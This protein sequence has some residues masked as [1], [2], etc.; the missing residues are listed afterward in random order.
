[1]SPPLSLVRPVIQPAP[2]ISP[3][4][5]GTAHPVRS[6][7]PQGAPALPAHLAAL[8]D[9]IRPPRFGVLAFGDPR[10]DAHLSGG[11][12]ALGQLHEIGGIGVGTETGAL[13][14]GFAASLAGRIGGRQ[15]VFWI[16]PRPDLYP[17]G[18]TDFGLDPARLVLVRPDD[19]DATLAAMETALREGGAGVVIGEVETLDRVASRRLALACARH[20]TTCLALRRWP[21]GRRGEDRDT[22]LAATRWRLGPVPSGSVPSD[23]DAKEPGPPR[24]LLALTQARGGRPGEWIVEAGDFAKTGDWEDAPYPVRVVAL[25]ADPAAAPGR[26]AG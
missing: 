14:A 20:G 13:S 26:L 9:H 3:L 15:P 7:M 1:M 2:D 8:R 12:L 10:I 24:W 4:S 17:H 11:G 25:L 5:S 23:R 18:L 21:Y 16:A 22:S 19:S 6:G